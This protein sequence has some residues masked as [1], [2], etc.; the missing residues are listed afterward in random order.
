MKR[1]AFFVSVLHL[2]IFALAA[3]AAEGPATRIDPA[4]GDEAPA[5]G[6]YVQ[7]YPHSTGAQLLQYCEQVDS[8]VSRLRCDYY[9]QGVAD[10]ATIP[11]AGKYM[12][13]IPQGQN[14]SQLMEIALRTLKAVKPEKRESES[15]AKLI[16]QGF[17]VSFPCA[18]AMPAP[19][20][21]AAQPASA[22]VPPGNAVAQAVTNEQRLEALRKAL[23]EVQKQKES[24]EALQ[25]VLLET[26][27]KPAP[28][29]PG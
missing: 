6:P 21:A 29:A 1:C 3:L 10:L 4:K 20:N 7:P 28:K 2:S 12:A 8:V 27:K 9:V 26:Q 13:C 24:L 17:A 18:A 25:K 11:Q 15:A 16:L 5:A 22:A 14:R 23:I 19:V